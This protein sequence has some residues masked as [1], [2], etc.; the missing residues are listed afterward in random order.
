MEMTISRSIISN[1][2]SRKAYLSD[3]KN[4]ERYFKQEI[5]EITGR[6]TLTGSRSWLSNKIVN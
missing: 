3:L 1:I 5:I 6:S 2:T 4:E